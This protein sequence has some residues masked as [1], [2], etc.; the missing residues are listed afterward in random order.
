MTHGAVP[1]RRCAAF[2]LALALPLAACGED[3]APTSFETCKDAREYEQ[4][5]KDEYLEVGR[6]YVEAIAS[7]ADQDDIDAL[8][9]ETGEIWDA[10][11]DVVRSNPSCF[12]DGTL[13]RIEQGKPAP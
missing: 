1:N 8:N 10:Q 13:E 5:L 4:E 9:D 6:R 12:P 3:E 2:L 7:Q 11:A